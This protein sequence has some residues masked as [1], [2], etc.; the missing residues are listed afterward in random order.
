MNAP[1]VALDCETTGLSLYDDI[2]EFAAIRR[3]PDGTQTE[4]HLFIEHHQHMCEQLPEAFLKDHKN[5]WPQEDA[6]V[7]S[8]QDAAKL[9]DSFML[10]SGC[11]RVHVIGAVP[12]FDTERISLLLRVYG[13]EPRWHYHLL[14][15]ENLAVGYIAGVVTQA[16]NDGQVE[17]IDPTVMR[18]PWNSDDLSRA[19]GVAAPGEGERHTAMGDARWALKLY[20]TIIGTKQADGGQ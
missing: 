5:R 4:T 8:R 19:C 17:P 9:I 13:Y 18:L 2:W 12:N 11:N 6:D 14:D 10:P 1:I 20:D 15:V 16:V 7:V 3:E